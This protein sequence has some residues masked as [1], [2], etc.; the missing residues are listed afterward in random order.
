MMAH[1]ISEQAMSGFSDLWMFLDNLLKGFI[2]P[3]LCL[4]TA[5]V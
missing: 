5:V 4:S 2:I 1:K 3:D